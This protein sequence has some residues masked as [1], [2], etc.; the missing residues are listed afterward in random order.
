MVTWGNKDEGGNS[1]DVQAALKGVGMTY[2][3]D[4]KVFTVLKEGPVVTWGD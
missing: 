4:G 3:A 1:H 2:F